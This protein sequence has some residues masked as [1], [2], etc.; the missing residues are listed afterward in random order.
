M[1][2]FCKVWVLIKMSNYYGCHRISL[3]N[4]F[5]IEPMRQYICHIVTV[6]RHIWGIRTSEFI[7][8]GCIPLII[9]NALNYILCNVFSKGYTFYFLAIQPQEYSNL[10]VGGIELYLPSGPV[11]MLARPASVN[12]WACYVTALPL[13]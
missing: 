13:T 8:L 10:L 4:P 9:R 6:F 7:I 12:T 1:G 11:V 2:F 3:A 5:C